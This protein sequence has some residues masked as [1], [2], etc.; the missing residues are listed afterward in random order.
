MNIFSIN[1]QVSW[2]LKC[3]W[4]PHEPRFLNE[5]GGNFEFEFRNNIE[6][7]FNGGIPYITP[8][9]VFHAYLR[10]SQILITFNRHQVMH[11]V[12][13]IVPC[14]EATCKGLFLMQKHSEEQGQALFCNHSQHCF[15]YIFISER[16]IIIFIPISLI[17]QLCCCCTDLELSPSCIVSLEKQFLWTSMK[18]V[19]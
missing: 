18:G 4:S 7:K 3:C 2:Q 1:Y 8:S 13:C 17:S 5:W 15:G 11:S 9:V 16:T 19:L 6:N 12:F 10:R 14:V